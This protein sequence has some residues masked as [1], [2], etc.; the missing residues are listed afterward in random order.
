MH[1]GQRVRE[2]VMHVAESQIK[3]FIEPLHISILFCFLVFLNLQI[4]KFA[5]QWKVGSCGP[6]YS[7]FDF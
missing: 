1:Q 6:P 4:I 5:L 7:S 3:F 2:V